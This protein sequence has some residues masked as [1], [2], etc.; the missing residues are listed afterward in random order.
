MNLVPPTASSSSP[1]VFVFLIIYRLSLRIYLTFSRVNRR[2]FKVV[3]VSTF[4]FFIFWEINF[5]VITVLFYYYCFVNLIE[6]TEKGQKADIGVFLSFYFLRVQNYPSIITNQI[7]FNSFK[8]EKMLLYYLST[9]KN[10]SYS[11]CSQAI[12]SVFN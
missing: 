11:V 5:Q 1:F 4:N 8:I 6:F 9:P 12:W 7:L 10:L 3:W 2:V